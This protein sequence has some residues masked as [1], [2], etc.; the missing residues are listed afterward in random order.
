V[1]TSNLAVVLGCLVAAGAADMISGLFRST[2]WNQSV[3]DELRGRLAG[4]EFL[5][6][7]TGPMLGNARAGF[8]AQLTGVRMAIVSGGLLCVAAV[9]AVAAALPALRG[10]DE[11]DT[12]VL[13]CG[14]STIPS[15]SKTE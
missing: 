9:G 4:I 6:Y 5:S 13:G 3:P 14:S 10:Y 15:S 7:A 11:R 1:P 2:I 12:K 8:A